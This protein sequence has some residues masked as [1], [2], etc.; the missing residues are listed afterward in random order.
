MSYGGLFIPDPH[1]SFWVVWLAQ[2]IGS[3]GQPLILNNVA[4][5]AGDWFPINE[6]DM[7]VT[8]AVVARSVH[9]PDGPSSI[10]VAY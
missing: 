9:P 6:R 10:P 5:L 2:V 3:F 4:L 7:A 1:A 8:I